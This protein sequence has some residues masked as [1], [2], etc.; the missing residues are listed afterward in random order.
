MKGEKIT[1][2]WL[3]RERSGGWGGSGE[4]EEREGYDQ[5]VKKFSKI[6]NLKRKVKLL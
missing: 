6:K 1:H 4:M 3:G 2:S 5:N